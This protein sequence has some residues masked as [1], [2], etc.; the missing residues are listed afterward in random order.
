[1]VP[2]EFPASVYF[3]EKE[4][5]LHVDSISFPVSCEG[6]ESYTACNIVG[7]IIEPVRMCAPAH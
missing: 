2:L 6:P 3:P 5:L 1:M 4:W 7:A